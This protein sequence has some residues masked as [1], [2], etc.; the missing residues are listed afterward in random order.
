[1]AVIETISVMSDEQI[2]T[3]VG[4]A[5]SIWSEHYMPIIGA[6]Q[7]E[8]M[9]GKYQ[10]YDAIKESISGGCR[11]FLA[12]IENTPCG[13]CAFKF[14]KGTFLSKFYVEKDYRG[15]GV[16]H[17]MLDRIISESQSA[18]SRRIWLTCNKFNSDTIGIYR[19]MGFT[20]IDSIITDIGNGF[21]MDDYVLEK[22]LAS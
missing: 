11:Y 3:V 16:G 15:K 7:I 4:L 5:A 13:Y 20:I 22:T 21:V 1:M 18:D 19:N 12:V 14:E 17:A 8:Y 6:E 9:L 2:R 10:S